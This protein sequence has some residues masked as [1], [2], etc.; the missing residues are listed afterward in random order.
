M[1]LEPEQ[2]EEMNNN[3]ATIPDTTPNIFQ[4]PTLSFQSVTNPS[5]FKNTSNT[6][7]QLTIHRIPARRTFY[8]KPR[9]TSIRGNL[10]RIKKHT[11]QHKKRHILTSP[12]SIQK[13]LTY[14]CCKKNCISSQ[15]THQQILEQRN[16]YSKLNEQER[17]TYIVDIMNSCYTCIN[18]PKFIY[19]IA[20]HTVCS[21]ALLKIIG[22]SKNTFPSL[23]PGKNYMLKCFNNYLINLLLATLPS[24]YTSRIITNMSSC[25]EKQCLASVS[26]AFHSPNKGLDP[27]PLKKLTNLLYRETTN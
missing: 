25:Q 15:F 11:Y 9:R 23:S 10:N 22:F 2:I 26:P 17:T 7:K 19:R 1:E 27:Y 6:H 3:Q 21:T 16:I 5:A 24:D 20:Y 18:P 8:P 14:Q 4:T 12:L 13:I